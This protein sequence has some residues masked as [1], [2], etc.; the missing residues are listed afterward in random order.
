MVPMI[1]TPEMRDAIDKIIVARPK[2]V[3]R[4]NDYVFAMPHSSK[5][6]MG[7]TTLNAICK[8]LL[9]ENPSAVTSTKIRKKIASPSQVNLFHFAL[10][11]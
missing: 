1:L 6:Y 5:A 10:L 2:F 8:G 4:G 3:Q 9:L 11:C 7:W